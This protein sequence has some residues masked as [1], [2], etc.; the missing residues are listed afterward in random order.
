MQNLGMLPTRSQHHFAASEAEL[1]D[2]VNALAFFHAIFDPLRSEP[3]LAIVN[4][5]Q[6]VADDTHLPRLD[7]LASKLA[8]ADRP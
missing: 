5:W 3:V 1:H 8:A 2:L 4:A 7:A 6:D